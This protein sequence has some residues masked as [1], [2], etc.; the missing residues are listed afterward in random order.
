MELEEIQ[1]SKRVLDPP[2]RISEILFGLI[3]V[4]TFTGALSVAEADRAEVQTMLIGA[5]GCNLAWGMID[6]LFYLM[7]SF[8]EKGHGLKIYRAVRG[9]DDPAEAQQLIGDALPS[10]I[11]TVIQPAEFESI[12]HRLK[13]LPEAPDRA[14]L[15]REDWLGALGV[16]LLVFLSTFPV[17]IPF[18][19]M[20]DVGRALRISNII[21]VLMLFLLGYAYG[22][23]VGGRPWLTGLVMFVLGSIVVTITIALGG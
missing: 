13:Q 2:E 14:H 8:A 17:V 20:E 11:A 21:A 19:F 10:V 22:V 6:G 23:Y 12:H 16:F 7:G 3:M 1:S 9:T 15:N 5:I 4:L 18:L